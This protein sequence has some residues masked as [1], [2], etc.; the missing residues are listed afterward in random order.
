[1]GV[2]IT[3]GAF[4]ACVAWEG[5]VAAAVFLGLSFGM[6]HVAKKLDAKGYEMEMVEARMLFDTRLGM[7]SPQ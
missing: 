1:M 6:I 3:G 4:P 5:W 7:H 2:V